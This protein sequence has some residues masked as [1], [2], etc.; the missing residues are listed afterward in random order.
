MDARPN[1]QIASSLEATSRALGA[2]VTW[3]GCLVLLG[4]A[5]D[6]GLLKSLLPGMVTMKFNT[7][8]ALAVAGISLRSLPLQHAAPRTIVAYVFAGLVLAI[9]LVTIGEY[10]LDRNLGVDELFVRDTS[11]S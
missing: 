4:W 10:L 8:L 6:I 5:L 2:A 9:G 11:A 7:A 3:I 1:T